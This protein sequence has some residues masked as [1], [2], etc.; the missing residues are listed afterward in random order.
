MEF[1]CGTLLQIVMWHFVWGFFVLELL[2][3]NVII[4]FSESFLKH[5]SCLVGLE[6]CWFFIL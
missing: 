2:Y 4:G 6:K 3:C 1:V 5:Y